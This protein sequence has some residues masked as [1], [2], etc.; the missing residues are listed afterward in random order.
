MVIVLTARD[1]EKLETLAKI[2][3]AEDHEMYHGVYLDLF[4]LIWDRR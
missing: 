3:E 4:D 1:V 2:Q